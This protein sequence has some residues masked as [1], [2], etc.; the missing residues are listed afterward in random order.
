MTAVP[1]KVVKDWGAIRPEEAPRR[2]AAVAGAQVA[3]ARETTE[4]QIAATLVQAMN[5]AAAARVQEAVEEMRANQVGRA[6]E[7]VR[8]KAVQPAAGE[9]ERAAPEDRA[10]EV[11][12]VAAAQAE[13]VGLEARATEVV[14]AAPAVTPG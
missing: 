7:A 6:G 2:A 12:R 8:A 3:P 10:A 1:A 13:L 11:H 14:E 5:P 9:V 4:A